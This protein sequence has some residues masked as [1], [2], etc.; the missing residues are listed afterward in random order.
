MITLYCTVLLE[1]IVDFHVVT[2]EEHTQENKVG[3]GGMVT[4]GL[5]NPS[6]GSAS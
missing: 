5:R 2:K 6:R 3:M 1:N 4:D